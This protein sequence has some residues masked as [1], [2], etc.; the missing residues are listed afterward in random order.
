M[1]LANAWVNFVGNRMSDTEMSRLTGIPRSTIGF[2]HR[3]E[4]DLPSEYNSVMRNLYQRTA[5]AE[6]R[7]SGASAEIAKKFSWYSPGRV[8]QVDELYEELTSKK[9]FGVTLREQIEAEDEGSPFNF[10][11]RYTEVLEQI[12][13]NYRKSKKD[14]QDIA[15]YV[16]TQILGEEGFEWETE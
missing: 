4:R 7:D 5:Y 6:M 12:K 14:W 3:G 16:T 11:D 10:T 1:S 9:A 2:V 8:E 13:A 15:N